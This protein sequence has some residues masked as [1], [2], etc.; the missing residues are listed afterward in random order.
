MVKMLESV[1][2]LVMVAW[3]NAGQN[4]SKRLGW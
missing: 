4:H 3:Y 1:K 2:V